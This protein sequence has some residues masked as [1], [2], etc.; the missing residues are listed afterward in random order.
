MMGKK[1]SIDEKTN[2]NGFLGGDRNN[3]F[4]YGGPNNARGRP[5]LSSTSTSDT[6]SLRY[7]NRPEKNMAQTDV[8]YKGTSNQPF[9]GQE[10]DFGRGFQARSAQ[11][12]PSARHEYP[13][14]DPKGT[15]NFGYDD[16][17]GEDQTNFSGKNAPRG[18]QNQKREDDYPSRREPVPDRNAQRGQYNYN[19]DDN[20]NMQE[21][22]RGQFGRPADKGRGYQD[23]EMH[24]GGQNQS[25]NSSNYPPA[26]QSNPKQSSNYDNR[27]PFD[28]ET[29]PLTGNPNAKQYDL[30]NAANLGAEFEKVQTYP[31]REGC[32]RRFAME[33]LEKH[34]KI[35]RKVFF[36]K[37][38]AFD[39]TE[40]RYEDDMLDA[41]NQA[42]RSNKGKDKGGAKKESKVP[43][44]K[45]ESA[46]LQL[47]SK[48][49][50]GEDVKGTEEARL[51]QISKK[52][53]TIDCPTCGRNFAEEAG[54]RH[55]PFC[56]EK[57][58]AGKS[59]QSGNNATLKQPLNPKAK[60]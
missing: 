41:I 20:R 11:Q 3:L 25:R 48:K 37:R 18:T 32:K 15:R 45:L 50:R 42:K 58:K 16:N 7:N 6:P 59:K 57:S 17:H 38:K 19:Q 46:Q 12:Q 35:C 33:A 52:Q 31:C 9:G 2:N 28:P 13:P 39:M 56:A 40:H 47:A 49:A 53:D 10:G 34:E 14:A 36:E 30:R 26:P 23:Q 55:M 4:G 1:P 24:H 43:K 5:G 60:K 29:A 8:G 22:G 27:E 21:P 44:W 54:K 51:I